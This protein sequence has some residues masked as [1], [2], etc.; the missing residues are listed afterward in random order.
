VNT[1]TNPQALVSRLQ[2]DNVAY[3]PPLP[4]TTVAV[5]CCAVT[6]TATPPRVTE[7][8]THVAAVVAARFGATVAVGV[9]VGVG[10]DG[11]G[12]TRD[13]TYG[14]GGTTAGA[15]L[16]ELGMLVT[17]AVTAT[18]AALAHPDI[19]RAVATTTVPPTLATSVFMNS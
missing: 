16:P 1:L 3:D 18:G 2:N 15:R 7:H 11:G 12:A 4:F 5:R 13:V 19:S 14:A 8:A 10:R 17:E 9:V 6:C